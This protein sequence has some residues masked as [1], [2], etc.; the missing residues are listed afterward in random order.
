M[1][2]YFV[3]QTVYR[4]KRKKRQR[5]NI[6]IPETQ[7]SQTDISS[8]S[9][10]FSPLHKSELRTTKKRISHVKSD[11]ELPLINLSQ[12]IPNPDNAIE[13]EI[14]MDN[15]PLI[16]I[17]NDNIHQSLMTHTS[18]SLCGH[19]E[20]IDMNCLTSESEQ[21]PNAQKQKYNLQQ[22]TTTNP[23]NEDTSDAAVKINPSSAPPNIPSAKEFTST[24]KPSPHT[25]TINATRQFSMCPPELA[26]EGTYSLVANNMKL[27]NL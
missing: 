21:I 9:T 5:P 8:A 27:S 25:L 24:D 2:I 11:D 10:H 6:I 16:K 3:P 18:T 22:S 13:D 4:R 14:D 12:P 1:D 7:S 17:S 26:T 15:I 20:N 19:S 23:S